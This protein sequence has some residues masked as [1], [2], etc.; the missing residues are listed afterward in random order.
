MVL[1]N[2]TLTRR[3]NDKIAASSFISFLVIAVGLVEIVYSKLHIDLG[4]PNQVLAM[5]FFILLFVDHELHSSGFNNVAEFPAQPPSES[6]HGG[7]TARDL[8]Y[9]D[10]IVSSSAHKVLT[11][12]VL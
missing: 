9:L 6:H 8:D 2:A 10:Q 3:T 5:P 1:A 7:R 4:K 11:G 12:L